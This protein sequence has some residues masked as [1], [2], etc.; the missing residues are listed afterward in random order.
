M[1][2]VKSWISREEKNSSFNLGFH[3]Q[4]VG[5]IGPRKLLR[6]SSSAFGDFNEFGIARKLSVVGGGGSQLKLCYLTVKTLPKLIRRRSRSHRWRSPP[7]GIQLVTRKH[8]GGG[9]RIQTTET[10]GKEGVRL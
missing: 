10:A 9:W 6:A 8:N 4:F 5:T 1:E 7:L 2:T 3:F